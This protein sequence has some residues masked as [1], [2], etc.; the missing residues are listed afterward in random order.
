VQE[1][2]QCRV[3]ARHRRQIRRRCHRDESRPHPTGSL[4]DRGRTRR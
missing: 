4:N 1:R 3:G 2:P